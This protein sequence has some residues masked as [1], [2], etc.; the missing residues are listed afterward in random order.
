MHFRIVFEI[1]V[2]DIFT[3]LG[4]ADTIWENMLLTKTEGFIEIEGLNYN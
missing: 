4:L 3:N 1:N 2:P